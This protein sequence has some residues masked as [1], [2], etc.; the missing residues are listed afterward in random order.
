MG[1]IFNNKIS[2]L[3]ACFARKWTKDYVPAVNECGKSSK[4][5]FFVV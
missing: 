1:L 5:R 4:K 3:K 2:E